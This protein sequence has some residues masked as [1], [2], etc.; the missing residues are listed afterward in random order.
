MK[1]HKNSSVVISFF[2]LFLGI[3][4]CTSPSSPKKKGYV[5]LD[6]PKATYALSTDSLPF[7]FDLSS[8]ARLSWKMNNIDE[9]FCNIDYPLLNARIYCT[10]HAITQAKFRNFAEESRRMAYQHTSVATGI[11]ERAYQN[12]LSHVY[13][14]IYD[15]KGDVATPLQVALTDS[16]SYFFN[17]S[18][19]FNIVPNADS[20]APAVNY[21]RK[22]IVR[23]MESFTIKKHK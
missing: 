2:L 8:Q 15:I 16:N 12:N 17:A 1:N 14:L 7:V 6:F 19:Y 4:A 23:M 9:Y 11:N 22:D 18:L 20:I 10:Y 13:G 5:R 21:I 3:T